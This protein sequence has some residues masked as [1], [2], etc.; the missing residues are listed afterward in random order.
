[1]KNVLILIISACLAFVQNAMAQTQILPRTQ[2]IEV[3][4]GYELVDTVMVVPMERFDTTLAG[5]NVFNLL[6]S[7]SKGDD[8]D[9]AVHQSASIQAAMNSHF[10]TNTD[11]PLTGYRVRIFFDNS[12]T[13]RTNSETTLNDFAKEHPEV[14][15]YRSYTN[16]YFKV[17]VGDFRTKSEA[18]ELL[19][20]IKG[21][22]PSAFIV[23]ENINFPV[24][25]KSDS[26]RIDT[27]KFLRPIHVDEIVEL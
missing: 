20:K 10:E 2:E 21:D 15:A 12:Q 26:Y 11:K 9:V 16:P 22:Y 13:A 14:V 6:P 27:L 18:M 24:V 23:K 8:V 4:E 19:Q 1:M 3:P 17:T 5:K 7:K 25:D